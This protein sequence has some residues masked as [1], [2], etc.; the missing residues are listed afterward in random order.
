MDL[1]LGVKK[2]RTLYEHTDYDHINPSSIG[3]C[4]NVKHILVTDIL[5]IQVNNI[6]EGMRED[7]VDAKFR[8]SLGAAV[9]H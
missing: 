5:L 1:L 9:R 4:E 3:S 6:L 7:P 2:V 8:E